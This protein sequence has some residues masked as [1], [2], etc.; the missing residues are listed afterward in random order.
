MNCSH[1]IDFEGKLVWSK[2][3]LKSEPYGFGELLVADSNQF[4]ISVPSGAVYKTDENA[5]IIWKKDI[6]FKNQI[7]NYINSALKTKSNEYIFIGSSFMGGNFSMYT[8]K[9]DTNGNK[10]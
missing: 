10:F 5:K 9:L 7:P 8:F 4:I 3:I 6:F 1:K 2:L